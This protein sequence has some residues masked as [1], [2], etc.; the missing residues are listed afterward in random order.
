[1]WKTQYHRLCKGFQLI[2][3]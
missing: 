1:M 2:L 3:R